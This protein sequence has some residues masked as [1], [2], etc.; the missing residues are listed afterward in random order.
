MLKV[1]RNIFIPTA[2]L[3]LLLVLCIQPVHADSY[4]QITQSLIS[5]D[6]LVLNMST[7]LGSGNTA[8]CYIVYMKTAKINKKGSYEIGNYEKIQELPAG[9]TAITITG[10]SSANAYDVKVEVNYTTSTGKAATYSKTLYDAGLIPGKVTGLTNK[11]NNY[12][13]AIYGEWDRQCGATG[14][15]W[16]IYDAKNKLVKSG[17]NKSFNSYTNSMHKA[18]KKTFYKMR[19]RAYREWNGTT[20]Y[21]EWSD[22]GY[23]IY[24]PEKIKASFKNKKMKVSWNKTYGATSYTV[25]VSTNLNSGY[26]AVKTVSANKTKATVKKFGKGKFKKGKTYYVYIRS[27]KKIGNKTFY[28]SQDTVCG[29]YRSARCN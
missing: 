18:K 7:N 6:S 26:K 12:V 23:C 4:L 21:G 25:M 20:Y 8:T 22:F 2:A 10:L 17:T 27:N 28:S 16:Q 24:P 1:L 29:N 3:L 14:Y 15:E 11:W 19:V 5:E 13:E 9:T